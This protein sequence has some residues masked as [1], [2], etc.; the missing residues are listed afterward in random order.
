MI[1]NPAQVAVIGA[2]AMGGGIAAQFANAG[3]P[4]LLLDRPS[5]GA[6][7]NAIAAAGLA[8]QLAIGGFMH[9]DQAWLIRI[10]NTEDDLA[11][12]AE[13]EWVVE[14]VVENLAVKQALYARLATVLAPHAVLS[15]NTS[16]LPRH[17]LVQGLP[18]D[19]ARRVFITHFFNPPRHMRLLELVSADDAPLEAVMAV[20]G[21]GEG[22]L[23]KRVV[24]CRDTPGFIANRLGCYWMSVAAIEAWRH[25][26]DPEAADALLQAAGAPGTGVFGLL[27]L[28]GIDLVP[29]VWG[30]LIDALPADDDHH[31]YRLDREPA[32]RALLDAGR[33]GR[34]RGAGFYRMDKQADGGRQLLVL[35]GGD[36]RPARGLKPPRETLPELM[37]G[38]DAAAAYLRAVVSATVAYACACL[39]QIAEDADAVDTAMRLGYNWRLGPFEL[40]DRAGAS[41]LVEVRAEAGLPVPDI[42]A[43]AAQEGGF[44]RLH[45]GHRES[46]AADGH[47]RAPVTGG[48]LS[49]ANL[50]ARDA[51]IARW[52]DAVLWDMGE[53]VACF[54]ATT[55]LGSVTAGLLDA[56]EATIA[57]GGQ[58]FNALVI[59]H[60]DP[61]AFSVGAD[62]RV[63]AQGLAAGDVAGLKAFVERGQQVYGALRRAAFPSVGAVA[64]LT[65]GGGLEMLLHCD[66]R[67][68]HA[69]SQVGLPERLVGI[70]PGWGGS[71][72]LL[73]RSLAD[74]LSPREAA[75]RAL[76]AIA[77]AQRSSS[78]LEAKA[79]GWLADTD[80]IVM[81]RDHVLAE[82]REEAL[83][84][85]D[86]YRPAAAP[87]VDL[88][89]V[90]RADLLSE[91]T[92]PEGCGP[93]DAVIIGELATLFSAQ[94]G[95]RSVD[96]LLALER[97]AIG[98]LIEHP[99]TAA[100]IQAMLET[101][102]PLA[103]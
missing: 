23:G 48:L 2:G 96:D 50:A 30:S 92:M 87:R 91:V 88:S 16:T 8:R 29:D 95:A 36:Y 22:V 57:R 26:I 11:A 38:N 55:K 82:A 86:G 32:I 81:N 24:D 58:D 37:A 49:I 65:L 4:V 59:G 43:R 76:A 28:V 41:A 62:L 94:G 27:D 6:E 10:G 53:G 67:V 61:R 42:L 15:S 72:A 83:M 98:R 97:A 52:P 99:A 63:F 5:D 93:Q 3:V 7:R 101:G 71:T 33:H 89:G 9:P 75:R 102:K 70:I 100:R 64:G 47:W 40:A 46:R 13:A 85:A 69:E 14:A 54:A 74:E 35:E 44:Y 39:P 20:R 17:A 34:K 77:G 78:A 21:W 73:L 51:V 19:V 1:E 66:S 31:R 45:A 68:A 103:N 80:S 12:V 79:I 60:D 25:G 18:D 56:L 90:D 84:L